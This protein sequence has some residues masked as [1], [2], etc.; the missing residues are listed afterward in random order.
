[1]DAVQRQS[2]VG[3]KQEGTDIQ[4]CAGGRGHP[5]LIHFHQLFNG[6][7]R[8][9]RRHLGQ[10]D[11]LGGN[12]QTLHI[13]IVAEQLHLSILAAVGLQTLKNLAGIMQ[14]AGGRR[15]RQGAIGHDPG[16]M[17]AVLGVIFH[18]EH[19][20]RKHR[21]K[22]QLGRFGHGAGIGILGNGEFHKDTSF[23]G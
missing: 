3:G 13:G 14:H 12:I 1:M 23:L 7:H 2:R 4:R 5:V 15:Q 20:V 16:I 18:N 21:A 6:C 9:I 19:M 17:P 22:A 10:A 8:H 11:P